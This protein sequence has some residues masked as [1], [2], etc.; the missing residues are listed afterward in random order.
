M[1]EE[2]NK[3]YGTYYVH[4]DRSSRREFKKLCDKITSLDKETLV[5]VFEY[6]KTLPLNTWLKV[7]G[8]NFNGS[9]KELHCIVEGENNFNHPI[10]LFKVEHILSDDFY[11]PVSDGKFDKAIWELEKLNIPYHIP[12]SNNLPLTLQ[13]LKELNL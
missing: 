4:I 5:D 13:I 12:H 7:E 6:S 3:L 2:E 10:K 8:L 9:S 11:T 1:K